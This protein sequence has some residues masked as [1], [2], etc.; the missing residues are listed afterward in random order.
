LQDLNLADVVRHA[1][2]LLEPD[3]LRCQVQTH[4]AFQG[5]GPAVGVFKVRTDPVA[6]E[7]IIHNLLMNALQAMENVPPAQRQLTVTLS[8]GSGASAG[9]VHV[10]IR[11]SGP[12]ISPEALPRLFEPF[13]TT[14]EGGLGLGLSLC[15]TLARGLDATLVAR[16]AASRGAEFQ[17]TLSLLGANLPKASA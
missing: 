4:V 8:A 6:L 9:Q 11:D 13:F 2:D 10:V 1:L 16:N 5:H 12:G 3:L 14:R 7:Q 15:E 17:L